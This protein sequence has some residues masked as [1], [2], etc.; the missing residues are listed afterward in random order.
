MKRTTQAA[1]CLTL[2]VISPLVAGCGS[3]SDLAAVRGKVT[4]DGQPLEDAIVEFQPMSA[5]GSPSSGRTDADGQYE[6]MH[7]FDTPGAIPGEHVVTIRTAGTFF[8]DEGNEFER[9][10]SVPA[11]Y[12]TDTELK[13]TIDSGSNTIDFEL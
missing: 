6:L 2:L 12:N 3:D 9:E 1:V 11:R 4:L 7:T 8:D 10:E 5:D 13:R